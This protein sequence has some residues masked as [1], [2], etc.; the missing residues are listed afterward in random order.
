MEVHAEIAQLF[1]TSHGQL[2][3]GLTHSYG[4]ANLEKVEDAVQEA[5]L[6]A[7]QVWGYTRIPDNPEAWLFTVARNKLIDQLR[8]DRKNLYERVPGTALHAIGP[9][10]DEEIVPEHAIADSQ[11]KMI[12]ACCHPTLSA[13]YQLILSLKL[14]GGFSN[15]ELADALLKKE[16]AVAKAFTR[17]KK[18]MKAQVKNL[19]SPMGIG[20]RSRLFV[21]LRV[22]YLLFNEGY[23]TNAGTQV[24]KRDICYEAIRLALLLRDNPY[25]RHAELEALIA[26]MCFHASRFDAR[27]DAKGRLVDLE[28]QNRQL[29]NKELIKIGYHHFRLAENQPGETSRYYLEAAVSYEHCRASEFIETRWETILELYDKQLLKYDSPVVALN[30]LV[31]YYFVYGPDKARIALEAYEARQDFRASALYYAISAEILKGLKQYPEAL[32]ALRS[33]IKLSRNSVERLHFRKKEKL[34]HK[35]II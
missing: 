17:A 27:L 25:C 3:A 18:Q 21:V 9:V 30:R 13:Q 16:E 8:K 24:I 6:K 31:P 4:M 1:R 23:A 11:L 15:R 28:H 20:L 14:I 19:E 7:M 33:A 5:L 34:L 29:Y 26:L 12:F 10:I 2:V 32:G 22:I 35:L